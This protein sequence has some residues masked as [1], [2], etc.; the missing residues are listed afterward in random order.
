MRRR[1]AIGIVVLVGL[2]LLAVAAPA[3]AA[4]RLRLYRGETSQ[5]ERIRFVV[6]KTDSGRFVRDLNVRHITLTCEDQTT[7]EL[8]FGYGFGGPSV[9][10]TEGAFSFDD[11]FW[12]TAFHVAG[13]LGPLKGQ[14]TLSLALAQITPDEQAAQLCT[15]GELTW[16]VEFVRTL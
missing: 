6:G 13:D 5:G 10:I 4:P 7:V 14:G 15:S 1:S 8:G 3:H 2:L 11:V 12:D 9:P 16:T